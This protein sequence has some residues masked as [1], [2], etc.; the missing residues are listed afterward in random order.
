MSPLIGA[1]RLHARTGSLAR[2]RTPARQAA[3][4]AVRFYTFG[5]RRFTEPPREIDY[6]A[7]DV[8]RQI[9]SCQG[10]SC[11]VSVSI[12]MTDDLVSCRT[13]DLVTEIWAIMKERRLKEALP[14]LRDQLVRTA[15]L[16]S[17]R[18]LW[19]GHSRARHCG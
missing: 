14:V 13:T 12:I 8:V 4:P 9:R 19:G 5:Y 2:G 18:S 1:P 15:L 17:G 11:T 7:N 16:A 3:S 6:R 10:S